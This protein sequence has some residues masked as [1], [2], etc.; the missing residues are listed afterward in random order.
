VDN[1]VVYMMNIGLDYA[2]AADAEAD[3]YGHSGLQN[4]PLLTT[5]LSPFVES[6]MLT[7]TFRVTNQLLRL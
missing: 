1:N 6:P 2:I 5:F 7:M 4:K 3:A